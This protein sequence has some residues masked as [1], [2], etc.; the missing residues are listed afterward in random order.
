MGFKLIL[1]P[2][3]DSAEGPD[4]DEQAKTIEKRLSTEL[5]GFSPEI[6]FS[7]RNG[8]EGVGADFPNIV[9]DILALGSA[10]FLGIP[11]L[12]KKI[13]ETI[14]GWREI[15]SDVQKFIYWLTTQGAY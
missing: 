13:K 10:A 12:H 15:W 8:T 2:F 4:W 11:K 14:K 7:L 3:R 1:S 9:I 6:R 5:N